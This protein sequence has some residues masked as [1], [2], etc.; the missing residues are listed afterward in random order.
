MQVLPG[1]REFYPEDCARRN[2]IT[3]TWRQVARRFGF[4]ETDGPCLEPIELYLKKSGGELAGQ[5]FDFTD[6][7]GR[8]VALRPEMTPTLARMIAARE[9][10]FRKPV[11][12]FSIANFFRY[13]KQQRGR[14]REFLQFNADIFGDASPAADAELLALVAGILREFGLGPDDFVLRLSDRNAWLHLLQEK[15]GSVEGAQAFLAII[16][17]LEREPAETVEAKLAPFALSLAEVRAFIAR[18]REAAPALAA[19]CAELDA[20]GLRGFYEVDLTIVR[21]LA[22]YTGVV[23]EAFDRERRFRALAGGGRYDGLV[24]LLSDGKSDLPA[25]GAGLGDVTLGELLSAL[26]HTAG[27]L[28]AAVRDGAALDTYVVIADEAR[29]PEA[30]ALA[31]ALRDAG[32]RVDYPLGPAKVGR[33]FQNAEASGA[34]RAVVVGAEWPEIK[35]KDLATRTEQSAD[36]ETLLAALGPARPDKP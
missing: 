19:L 29:R 4:V 25:A 13:E 34:K 2:Y 20:R 1:F 21:G 30:L 7:G 23:F 15:T 26:P 10:D 6:K 17:K 12:W 11:K 18:G 14:L 28:A 3:S 5:L 36:R 35:I 32:H 31:A 27:R 9:R 16:D 22:Y 8:H 24:K 33:Q